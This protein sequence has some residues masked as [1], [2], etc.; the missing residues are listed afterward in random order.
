MER[1]QHVCGAI[2]ALDR[3]TGD[4]RSGRQGSARVPDAGAPNATV[5]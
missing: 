1:E 3:L 4:A 5:V 2:L